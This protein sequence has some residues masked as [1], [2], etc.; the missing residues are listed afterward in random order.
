M[1]ETFSQIGFQV[2]IN[3][4]WADLS[5]DVLDDPEPHCWN[6]GM[7]SNEVLDLV[8]VPGR[9]TFSL[10]NGKSNSAGLV[11]YYSPDH[12]NCRAG[13]TTGLP[14]RVFFSYQ[15]F[16][17]YKFY[18]R[19]EPDGITVIPGVHGPRRVDVS[20]IDFMGQAAYHRIKS[21]TPQTNKTIL[22]AVDLILAALPIQPLKKSYNGTIIATMPYIF[23]NIQPATTASSEFNK[24][25]LTPLFARI[26]V[27]GDATGG[28]TLRV[29]TQTSTAT[30]P[31]VTTTNELLLETGDHLL[32]EDGSFMLL[33]E[34]EDLTITDD[35]ILPDTEISYGNKVINSVEILD[36]PRK[37]DAAATTVLFTL[38]TATQL[39][40]GA[41]VTFWGTYHD[42]TGGDTRVNGTAMVTPVSG[43]DFKAFA[44]ADGTGTD[45]TAN[46]T[47]VATYFS[48]QAKFVVSNTGGA[49]FYFG[50]PSIKFQC[51]GKGIY[52]Y[53]AARVVA[54]DATS[55]A[56]HGTR[57]LTFDWL[58]SYAGINAQS[59]AN[60]ILALYKDPSTSID[61][62]K[63]FANKN[64]KNMM[65]FLFWEVLQNPTI[66]ETVTGINSSDYWMQG[67]SWIL[68]KGKYIYWDVILGN[69]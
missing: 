49:A 7:T 40:A 19:I 35:D 41:S 20:C 30:I 44:N 39:A 4:A 51:R 22:E 18:G 1:T 28:E 13:W 5:P 46:M 10:K 59:A 62:L 9:L 24:L 23:D 33:D 67:Y 3:G 43:T 25:A 54:E 65:A 15:G 57:P 38:Q 68:S 32:L 36:H 66:T 52:L 64:P 21:L 17:R 14:V 11:G 16:T 8:A 58:Y 50:G 42:P 26:F 34:T 69:A 63:L 48:A 12:A 56:I 47:V 2:Y 45:Y 61:T 60:S 27:Q 31:N 55:I 37:I 53:D 29:E 6:R